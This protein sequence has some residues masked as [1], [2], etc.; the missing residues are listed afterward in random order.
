LRI[1][2]VEDDKIEADLIRDELGAGDAAYAD[3]THHDRL[4]AA[5]ANLATASFD[6]VLLDLNLPD[7]S[8]VSNLDRVAA[9]APHLPVII[10]TNLSNEE[11]AVE[12]LEKGAKDYL[13]KRH[14][15]GELL[16]RTI[17]Y[18]IARC[19]ADASLRASE[20]RHALALAGAR[21]GIWDWDL[22]RG[23]VH[24]SSRWFELLQIQPEQRSQTPAIWLDRVHQEDLP[25]LQQ[26]L[27]THLEGRTTYLEHEHRIRTGVG[28]TIWV[29][30]RGVAVRDHVGR[31]TRLA[32]SLTDISDRKR[33]EA[34]LVHEALH[35]ALTGLPNRALF[36]D[37]LD[38]ALKQQRR[39]PAR[40]FA[41]LFLD[42]DGFKTTNDSLGHTAGDELLVQFGSRLRMFLRPGDS[43][44]RLG[45]D[46]F[47]IL[48]TDIAS[49]QEVARVAD[50][51]Q[52]TLARR[53]IIDS[54]ELYAGAS[55]GIALSNRSYERPGDLLRD[56]DA[57]MYQSKHGRRGSYTVFNGVSQPS[58]LDRL[59]LETDLRSA[60]HYNQ[61]RTYYQPIVSLD[62]R[63]VLGFEALVRWAHPGRGL[64]GPDAFLPLAE[65]CGTISALSWWVMHEACQQT[66]EWRA[67]D[68]RF[69]H[70]TVSV[71]VSSRL[72]SEP[73]FAART[74][75]VL[76]KA[77][78][79]PHALRLEVT[80]DALLHHDGSVVEEFQAL[81]RLGVKFDLDDFGTGYSSL[82][83]LNRFDYDTIKIDRSFIAAPTQATRH[84]RIV[85]ALISLA[86]VLG[87]DVIAEGVE[88]EEQ[89]AKLR[90]LKCRA[91]QGFLFSRPVPADAAETLL[92]TPAI[93]TAP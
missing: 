48:L 41:V 36:L 16:R 31:A 85:D 57:A 1:L 82:A 80:E 34:R 54:T 7:G 81:H 12:M 67:R 47:A 74:T 18:A 52:E 66:R 13:I 2:L 14:I 17:R 70:L 53:F 39:D 44:A 76:D 29:L 83:Y 73:D 38:V 19:E 6:V 61:M 58:A 42:I 68:P 43:I 51:I 46:E 65:K 50:R 93:G 55:I 3:I 91:A 78:L 71:N 25:G 64:L 49:A 40:A 11:S 60:L 72:L 63:Q 20:E 86:S 89:A 92:G 75:A 77:G 24:F 4:S 62:G 87:I 26:A 15:T 35:D 27:Q 22:V 84:R 28:H 5:L 8:G 59:E 32:G 37:R 69:E 30:C 45:G 88:T 79:A 10:L 90:A 33:A 9:A 21:D 56:A 23:Q